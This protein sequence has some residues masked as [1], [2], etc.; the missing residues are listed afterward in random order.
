MS[1]LSQRLGGALLVSLVK[2]IFWGGGFCQKFQ[3]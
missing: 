3:K 1:G 2:A